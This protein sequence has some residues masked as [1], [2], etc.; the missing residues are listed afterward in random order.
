MMSVLVGLIGTS[1]LVYLDD[2]I[3][4]GET[5]EEHIGNL[6]KIL[7]AFRRHGIKLK[8]EKCQF[9]KVRWNF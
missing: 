5:L 7:G 4:L 8:I 3:V 1:V 6:L 9:F 2:L